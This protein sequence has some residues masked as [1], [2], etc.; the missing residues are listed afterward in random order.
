MSEE[1]QG[2]QVAMEISLAAESR[3]QARVTVMQVERTKLQQ[4]VA[5][6][7][8]EVAAA[9]RLTGKEQLAEDVEGLIARLLRESEAAV[10]LI[11]N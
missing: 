9:D 2:M 8:E 7:E 5:Q 4:Q 10:S 6:L 11:L 3:L 1:L